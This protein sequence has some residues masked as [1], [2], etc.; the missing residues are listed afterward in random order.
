VFWRWLRNPQRRPRAELVGRAM[1]RFRAI[2]YGW[3]RW[4]RHHRPE[5]GRV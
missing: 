4:R 1:L 5:V 2:S 3:P